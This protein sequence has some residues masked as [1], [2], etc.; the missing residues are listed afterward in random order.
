MNVEKYK[1]QLKTLKKETGKEDYSKAEARS[2][3]HYGL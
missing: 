3:V 1:N 2:A